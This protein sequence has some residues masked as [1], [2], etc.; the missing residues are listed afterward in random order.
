MA[1]PHH[2]TDYIA[3]PNPPGEDAFMDAVR[4]LGIRPGNYVFPDFRDPK[5]MK[6]EKVERALNEGP[7]GHLSL[8][9]PPLGM[10]GK[11]VGTFIVYLVVSTVIAYLA[12]ITLSKGAEFGRV[13]RVVGTA[14]VLAYAFAFIPSAIWFGAYRRTII[15]SIIDGILFGLIT[16]A[17]FAWRWPH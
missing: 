12:S 7:V 15:A 8:W 13:F 11:M 17:I 9:Q 1:L 3:I 5:A 4:Q 16:G 2:K 6:S 10:A 14:G